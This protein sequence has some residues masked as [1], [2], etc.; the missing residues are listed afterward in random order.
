MKVYFTRKPLNMEEVKANAAWAK[1]EHKEPTTVIPIADVTLNQAQ[2][3]AFCASPC[4]DWA[5]LAPYA[6]KSG[7]TKDGA[8]CVIIECEGKPSIALALEGY[9][10]GRYVGWLI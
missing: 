10:Y 3:E 8:D 4:K 9:A 6:D 2:Y 1:A 7:F 5:F